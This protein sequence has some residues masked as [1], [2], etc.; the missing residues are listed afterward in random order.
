MNIDLVKVFTEPFKIIGKN[1]AILIPVFIGIIVSLLFGIIG[2]IGP[3]ALVVSSIIVGIISMFFYPWVTLH[4]KQVLSG[5]EVN[6]KESYSELKSMA[7]EILVLSIVV[8]FL[9]AIGFMA[10]V[11]PGIILALFLIF[12]PSALVVDKLS[13]TEAIKK[14]FSFVFNSHHFVQILIV[15]TIIFLLGLI[16]VVGVYISI[17]L[18]YILLPYIY[19][20][21]SQQ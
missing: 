15:L 16:P 14:S 11:V 10:F 21:Y 1:P 18:Q 12:S 9:I 4:F 7:L 20:V 17:L 2:L 8:G 5:S 13:V 19:V 6:L 3:V